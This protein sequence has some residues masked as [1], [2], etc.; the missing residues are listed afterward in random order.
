M[1]ILSNKVTEELFKSWMVEEGDFPW[2]QVLK[3]NCAKDEKI[4]L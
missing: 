2:A 3:K 1:Q 4:R